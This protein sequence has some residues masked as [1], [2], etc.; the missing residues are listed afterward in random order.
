MLQWSDFAAIFRAYYISTLEKSNIVNLVTMSSKIRKFSFTIHLSEPFRSD[1][2]SNMNHVCQVSSTGRLIC[3]STHWRTDMARSSS[4]AILIQNMYTLQC[5]RCLKWCDT[6]VW[7]QLICPQQEY[8]NGSRKFLGLPFVFGLF[9]YN[10]VLYRLIIKH[11]TKW[12]NLI[13]SASWFFL[14]SCLQNH[15]WFLRDLCTLPFN[16]S[17]IIMLCKSLIRSVE[18]YLTCWKCM[19]YV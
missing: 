13:L 3:G 12:W 6:T 19:Q 17:W 2:F 10:K 8:K 4:L 9:L 14:V 15:Q 18:W 16:H 5:L 7:P 1:L 11:F